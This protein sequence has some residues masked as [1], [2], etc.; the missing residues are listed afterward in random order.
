[1]SKNINN[2]KKNIID[3]YDDEKI[4]LDFLNLDK[5][6]QK[7][8]FEPDVILDNGD[9]LY[10]CDDF[11]TFDDIEMTT[12]LKEQAVIDIMKTHLKNT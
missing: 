4:D 10:N 5:E 8:T 7:P 11:D 3:E 9:I 1:M 12:G 6:L 2:L